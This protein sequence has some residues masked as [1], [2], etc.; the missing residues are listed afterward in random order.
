[1][2]SIVPIVKDVRFINLMRF[3]GLFLSCLSFCVSFIALNSSEHMKSLA[4][5]TLEDF[6]NYG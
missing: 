5:A 4:V 2:P 6:L 3:H 1:M